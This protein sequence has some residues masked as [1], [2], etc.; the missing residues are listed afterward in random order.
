MPQK[1]LEEI[2]SNRIEI[3]YGKSKIK[4][5]QKPI[6]RKRLTISEKNTIT[7]ENPILTN[8]SIPVQT[9]NYIDI[10]E[11]TDD[12]I[13]TFPEFKEANLRTNNNVNLDINPHRNNCTYNCWPLFYILIII[14]LITINNIILSHFTNLEWN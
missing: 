5:K 10:G 14:L 3:T 12:I 6:P 2:L 9:D 13:R 4:D 8:N 1:T 11:P 7:N